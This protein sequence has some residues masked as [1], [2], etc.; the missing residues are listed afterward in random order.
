[1]PPKPWF[2][3]HPSPCSWLSGIPGSSLEQHLSNLRPGCS[4]PLRLW[5]LPWIWALGTISFLFFE[6][7][8]PYVAWKSLDRW[9][10]THRDR[11][12]FC[13]PSV[14]V[15]VMPPRPPGIISCRTTL[16]SLGRSSPY[17]EHSNPNVAGVFFSSQS[18]ISALAKLLSSRKSNRR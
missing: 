8:F 9:S 5:L 13:L 12:C 3:R 1:M 4:G 17:T 6:A 10:L 18:D 7:E 14:G 2:L 16:E 11:S 15:K